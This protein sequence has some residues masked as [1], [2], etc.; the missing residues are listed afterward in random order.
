LAA[1]REGGPGMLAAGLG[2]LAH[3]LRSLAQDPGRAFDADSASRAEAAD[4]LTNI[5]ACR[6]VLDAMEAHAV[7]ALQEVTRRERLANA[8]DKAEREEAAV[9]SEG[10]VHEEADGV[11][12]HDLT[13]I[14]HRSPHAAG[15]TL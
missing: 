12:A 4:L 15:R 13:L 2:D 11:T 8:R 7:V 10:V 1:L 9:P 5:H 3:L 14:T 6:G